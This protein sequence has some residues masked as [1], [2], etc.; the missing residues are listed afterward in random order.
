MLP[1]QPKSEIYA[2]ATRQ[3]GVITRI[4]L[5][6][7]PANDSIQ[8]A[9]HLDSV[10]SVPNPILWSSRVG[11]INVTHGY[12]V[13]K[14]AVP[15]VIGSET[16]LVPFSASAS[17]GTPRLADISP[18][19]I[20][21]W[22]STPDE[23]AAIQSISFYV[24]KKSVTPDQSVCRLLGMRVKF[25]RGRSQRKKYIGHVE[26]NSYG[27]PMDWVDSDVV[28]FKVNGRAG[29]R[30]TEVAVTSDLQSIRVCLD[31]ILTANRFTDK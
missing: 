17:S 12:P 21:W 27:L 1:I 5:I 11:S 25:D 6:E 20:L 4:G 14:K 9:E 2:D 30:I 31:S 19:E 22:H 26:K 23:V 3:T 28:E 24:P 15:S 7:Y 8:G 10:P 18:H 13:S 16:E 29:E